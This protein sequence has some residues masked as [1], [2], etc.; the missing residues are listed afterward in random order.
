MQPHNNILFL[1]SAIFYTHYV[2]LLTLK[3]GFVLNTCSYS[4]QKKKFLLYM[5]F[6]YNMLFKLD[7]NNS[8]YNIDHNNPY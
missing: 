7:F 1:S 3:I 5:L 2:Q 8:N 6:L 4:V